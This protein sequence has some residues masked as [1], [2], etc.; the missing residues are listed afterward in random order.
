MDVSG[1]SILIND[2]I[3]SDIGEP[4]EINFHGGGI[5]QT[6]EGVKAGYA[7]SHR[8]SFEHNHGIAR[9][10]INT[11]MQWIILNCC[12]ARAIKEVIIE[13]KEVGREVQSRD[14]M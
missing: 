8:G 4:Q 9:N 6:D 1:Q 11:P 2:W 5:A 13:K 3:G 12:K 7:A 14:S 10:R